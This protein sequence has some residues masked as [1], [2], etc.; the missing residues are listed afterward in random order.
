[1]ALACLAAAGTGCKKAPA[2]PSAARIHAI[3]DE[4]AAEA[5]AHGAKAWTRKTAGD[6]DPSSRD[7]VQIILARG[8]SPGNGK[9]VAGLLQGLEQVAARNELT[10]DA[11]ETSGNSLHILLRRSG[12][13]THEIEIAASSGDEA[14]GSE[15]RKLAIIVDDLG[16][17]AV[18]A[19]AAFAIDYPLT[20]SVLPGQAHSKEIA[21]EADRRGY[22]VMLHL[23]MESIGKEQAEAHELRRGMS[24]AQVSNLVNDFL[25]DVPHA[26]GVNNHQGSEATSDRTLMAELMPILRNKELFYIDSRTTRETVAYDTA[27]QSGVASAFRNVP[28]LDDVEEVAA[29]RKQLELAFRGAKEKG[30]AVAIGHPH[31]ATF[32]ALRE[33]LPRA[34]GEGIRLVKASEL[35]H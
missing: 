9:T 15:A 23:P 33:V 26:R 19:G 25:A 6:S 20:L 1:M 3:S 28:F 27:R 4:L 30:E 22:E 10:E 32:E 17:D 12:R 16:G 13:V 2:K 29:I 34:N 7:A 21:L 18:A 11:P 5:T 24:A 14:N 8:A 31:A 35:V